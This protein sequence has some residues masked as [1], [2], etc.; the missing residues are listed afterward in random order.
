LNTGD[1]FP[2]LSIK[3]PRGRALELP[4]AFAGDFG[5]VLVYRGAWCPYC[6][7][8]LAAF[9]HGLPKLADIGTRIVA[10]SVDDEATTDT[11]I[12]KH[13][14]TFPV[15]HGADA[16]EV[17]GLLGSFVNPEPRYLQSTGFLLGPD[18]R[19]L[20]SVYSSG[21]IGLLAVNEVIRYVRYIRDR[22]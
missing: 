12:A 20:V 17:A 7:A 21:A 15:G 19:V 1:P 18:G 16:D 2:S 22:S 11:L 3:L 10:F 4:D 5:V 6:E 13:Q 8:Q 14:L 9:Q